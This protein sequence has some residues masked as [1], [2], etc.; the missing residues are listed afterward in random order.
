[1]LRDHFEDVC[2]SCSE[3]AR[4]PTNFRPEPMGLLIKPGLRVPD[5]RKHDYTVELNPCSY[6][7]G[8]IFAVMIGGHFVGYACTNDYPILHSE[9]KD[10]LEQ[11]EAVEREINPRRE[12]LIA[13]LIR[14]QQKRKERAR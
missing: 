13:K 14:R 10:H 11:P 12:G 8:E 5:A 2:P 1:M 4:E 9:R 3:T 6:C 7:G